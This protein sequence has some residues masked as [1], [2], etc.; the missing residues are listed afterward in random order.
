MSWSRDAE[1][2]NTFT[3]GTFWSILFICSGQIGTLPREEKLRTVTHSSTS[4]SPAPRVKQRSQD[5]EAAIYLTEEAEAA[6]SLRPAWRADCWQVR[7]AGRE[8]A[9]SGGGGR[10]CLLPLR[11]IDMRVVG[12]VSVQSRANSENRGMTGKTEECSAGGGGGCWG[13]G[14]FFLFLCVCVVFSIF[15]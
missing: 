6:A 1:D 12:S 13:G 2:P 10:E 3:Y 9:P 15:V 4:S 8:P 5:N 11:D 7:G 14:G